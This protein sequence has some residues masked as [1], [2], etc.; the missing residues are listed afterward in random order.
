MKARRAIHS[1]AIE[2]GHCRHLVSGA[3]SASSSGTEAPSRKLNAEAGVEFDVHGGKPQIPRLDLK[4]SLGM[5]VADSVVARVCEPAPILKIAV[6][7]V[8][9][10]SRHHFRW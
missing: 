6:N 5:A 2:Q 8:E 7:A 1:I 9:C 3:T 10:N 4:A